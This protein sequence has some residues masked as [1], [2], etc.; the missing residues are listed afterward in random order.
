M[1]NIADAQQSACCGSQ[2]VEMIHAT[3]AVICLSVLHH[4]VVCPASKNCCSGHAM[5]TGAHSV[6]RAHLQAALKHVQIV[7]K[8][9]KAVCMAL[10]SLELPMS[11]ILGAVFPKSSV[12]CVDK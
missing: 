10:H 9:L 6:G 11:V 2:V 4:A 1:P 3:C 12:Y 7:R 5:R 8:T